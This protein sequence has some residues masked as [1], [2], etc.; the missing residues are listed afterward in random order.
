[1]SVS[2]CLSHPVELSAFIICRGLCVY[3]DVVKC[4]CLFL[5]RVLGPYAAASV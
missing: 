3:L 1:M 5:C 2:L 4:P